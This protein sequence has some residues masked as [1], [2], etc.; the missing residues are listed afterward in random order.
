MPG[1]MMNANAKMTRTIRIPPKF[2]TQ[3]RPHK[4]IAPKIAR[5]I[6]NLTPT[7]PQ[8]LKIQRP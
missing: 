1:T 8:H 7:A 4:K 6:Y 5:K 2:S 3:C